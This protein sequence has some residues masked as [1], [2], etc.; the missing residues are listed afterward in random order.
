V[1]KVDGTTVADLTVS[2]HEVGPYLVWPIPQQMQPT[3]AK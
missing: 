1:E 2:E 3:A